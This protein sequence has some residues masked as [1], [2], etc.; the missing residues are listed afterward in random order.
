MLVFSI[1]VIFQYLEE[2]KFIRENIEEICYAELF[3]WTITNST[4]TP[5]IQEQLDLLNKKASI[6][7]PENIC[8]NTTYRNTSENSTC[9]S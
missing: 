4:P 6:Y 5:T 7:D 9:G 2:K 8:D 3:N 1:A